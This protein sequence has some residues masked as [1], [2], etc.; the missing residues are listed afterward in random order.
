MPTPRLLSWKM[1]GGAFARWQLIALCAA[2][3]AVVLGGFFSYQRFSKRAAQEE[4]EEREEAAFHA[5]AEAG[6]QTQAGGAGRRVGREVYATWYEV[7]ADSLAKRRAGI[8]ELTAAHNRLPLGTL[9]RVTHL[10]NGKNVTV[11]ITD[12]GNLG[13]KV[14][15]DVC[16]E[17][18]AELEM[19]SK[20]IARVRMEIIPETHGASPPELHSAAPQ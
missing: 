5:S 3:L 2:I 9:V 15:L 4:A 20:G 11:R 6:A 1:T 10:A 12:R 7:P 8:G 13:R 17:A 19:V 16:K 14:K 18:A